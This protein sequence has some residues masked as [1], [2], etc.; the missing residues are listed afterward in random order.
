MQADLLAVGKSPYVARIT[1]LEVS[2]NQQLLLCGDTGG[3][4]IAFAIPQAV[5]TPSHPT[6]RNAMPGS[7]ARC[8]LI[9]Q[10]DMANS[11]TSP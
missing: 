1:C 2:L 4:I 3:S 6:G 10:S 7:S 5:R 8:F 11:G 9:A